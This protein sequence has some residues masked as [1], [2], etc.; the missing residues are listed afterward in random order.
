MN[1]YII[2]IIAACLFL[3]AA[4]WL[5][6]AEN[7]R[8]KKERLRQVRESFG[9]ITRRTYT[10][11]E[12]E[13]ISDYSRKADSDKHGY[14]DDITWND[15]EMDMVFGRINQTLSAPGEEYLYRILRLP[16]LRET[17][18]YFRQ[19]I[20]FFQHNAKTREEIQLILAEIGKKTRYNTASVVENL[21]KA[22]RISAIPHLIQSAA[23]A[24]ALLLLPVFPVGG[25][26]AVFIL[27]ILNAFTYQTGRDRKVTEPC[28]HLFASLC[29]ILEAGNKFGKVSEPRIEKNCRTVAQIQSDLG[30]FRRKAFWFSS[31]QDAGGSLAGVVL[32]YLKLFFHLD[33]LIYPGLLDEAK[34]HRTQF[35]ELLDAVGEMDAAICVS[36]FREQLPWYCEPE[37]CVKDSRRMEWQEVYHP[38]LEN[39]VPNTICTSGSVLLTGSNASGKSTFLKAVAV[40]G[41]LAQT[42]YTCAARRYRAVHCQI[43]SSIALRDS[44]QDGESYFMAEI[45]SLKRIMDFA[46]GDIPL[47]CVIDEV[48][49]GTNTIERI[50]A[51]GSILRNL[52]RP[53]V[54]CFAATHDLELTSMLKNYYENYHFEEIV[55]G[56]DM[57]FPY[58]LQKGPSDSRNALILLEKTGYGKEIIA[59]ARAEAEQFQKNGSWEILK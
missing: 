36:S 56:E 6:S 8:Q 1:P 46:Q 9:T 19:M 48:L 35:Q 7:L 37:F 10:R 49:R 17:S 12:L 43:C 23:L 44:L 2:V 54:Y 21:E 20:D 52:A 31:G 4:G 53:F 57:Y 29:R 38:L 26:F 11:E 32:D 41:I 18:T 55:D 30:K 50:A 25:V 24:G 28:R 5:I 15:L 42:I 14:L 51:S 58:K 45:R 13:R 27:L 40:N 34:K 3:L 16:K 22:P 33:L 47:L 39:P 59:S